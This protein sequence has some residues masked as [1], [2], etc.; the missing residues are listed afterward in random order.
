MTEICL[1]ERTAS[2]VMDRVCRHHLQPAASGATSMSHIC[3]QRGYNALH[4]Q[5]QAYT[6]I[7][8]QPALR[9]QDLYPPPQPAFPSFSEQMHIVM[10][11]RPKQDEC[12]QEC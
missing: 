4:K 5:S 6:S 7:V 11:Q 8:L 2:A 10:G 12:Q 3:C 9:K 1:L